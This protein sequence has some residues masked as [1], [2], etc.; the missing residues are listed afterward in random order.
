MAAAPASASSSSAGNS[1]VTDAYTDLGFDPAFYASPY[2]HAST[3][4]HSPSDH[5][6]SPPLS[7]LTTIHSQ[8]GTSSSDAQVT[9]SRG[10]CWT[11]RLRRK[12]CD[13]QRSD[14]DSCATCRRLKLKCLGWGARRPDWM[15]VGAASLL[16]NLRCLDKEE[17]QRYKAEIKAHL[18]RQG[19]IRGQPRAGFAANEPRPTARRAATSP[20]HPYAKVPSP[21]KASLGNTGWEQLSLPGYATDDLFANDA[22]ASGV[23]AFTN[24]HTIFESPPPPASSVPSLTLPPLAPDVFDGEG[25][26]SSTEDPRQSLVNYY[27]SDVRAFNFMHTCIAART[28]LWEVLIKVKSSALESAMCALADVYFQWEDNRS[29][30][31]GSKYEETHLSTFYLNEATGRMNASRSTGR[32][33]SPDAIAAGHLIS[34]FLATSGGSVHSNTGAPRWMPYVQLACD[35]VAQLGVQRDP[36]P[37]RILRDMPPERSLAIKTAMVTDILLSVAIQQPPR[38]LSLWR[39]ILGVHQGVDIHISRLVGCTD[40][41]LLALGETAALAHWRRAEEHK[42]TLNMRELLE[43]AAAIQRALQH[44]VNPILSGSLPGRHGEADDQ[45]NM[46]MGGA[47][48]SPSAEEQTCRR[49][50]A[51][52]WWE[53]AMLNLSA[54][55]HGSN[56]NIDGTANTVASVVQILAAL[57]KTGLDRALVAPLML[58]AC[59]PSPS[60]QPVLGSPKQ[61]FV[62][63]DGRWTTSQLRVC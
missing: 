63:N 38:L 1:P 5:H 46:M 17:V 9:N 12:K 32:I 30:A 7:H 26:R 58:T 3:L 47:V 50:V 54:V 36:M 4:S 21:R 60:L 22:F 8:S 18:L 53:A 19:L 10:G 35:Y 34:Y 62:G 37:R 55:V 48:P 13:E 20:T 24:D 16:C 27:F 41:V 31:P 33:G 2:S 14:D 23:P 49:L 15:R 25:L 44:H 51:R 40:I 57:P 59:G 43:R 42:G 52:V 61:T 45:M 29:R 39:Q 28:T 11:C 56:T 6:S